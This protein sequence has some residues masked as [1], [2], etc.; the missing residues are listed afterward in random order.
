MPRTVIS[1]SGRVR[2]IRPLPSDSTTAIVPVSAT[3][4]FPP[5]TATRARRNFSRRWRRAASASSAGSS[6]R[7]S[8]AG[9]PTLPISLRKM[10]RISDRLRWMAGTR[11]CDG[12]SWPSWTMSSARSVSQTSMPSAA[13]ASLSSISWVVIDLTLTTSWASWLRTMSSDDRV[14]LGTVA[15]PVDDA[16]RRGDGTLESVELVGQVAQDLV[17]DRRA[18]Q[19]EGLPVGALGDHARSLG[20]DRRRGVA[21]V[22]P[23]LRVAEGCPRRVGERRGAP[24]RRDRRSID[25]RPLHGRPLHRRAHPRRPADPG[26]VDP[27]DSDPTTRR[28][29]AGQD[30]GQMHDPWPAS[31]PRQQPADVHQTRRVGGGQD[32]GAGGE[33]VVDLVVAHRHRR[34]GV[35]DRE[36]PAEPA[37][38]V[39]ALERHQGQAVDLGQQPLRAVPDPEQPDR[40]AGRVEHDPVR[41][42]RPDVGHAQHVDQELGQLV[43]PRARA[44]RPAPEASGRLPHPRRRPRPARPPSGGSDGPSRHT[45]ATGSPRH[46]TRRRRP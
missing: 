31:S 22:G 6:P 35:L 23:E 26:P 21:Q 19:P 34:V 40:V 36:R 44:R 9:R 4:K 42:A 28:L 20:P 1:T 11:M 14:G 3:A 17:L 32:L 30:L 45:T 15:R 8:G 12:R 43:D 39:G 10:S 24:E 38:L 13:S 25:G 16:A 27:G 33:H 7:S 37:A 5:E 29:R 18:G 46:R 2:H 41:E